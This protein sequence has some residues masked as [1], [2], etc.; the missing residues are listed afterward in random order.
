MKLKNSLFF[1]LFAAAAALLVSCNDFLDKEPS[2]STHKTI[3]TA[4]QLDAILGAYGRLQEDTNNMALAS[5][6]FAV[7]PELQHAKEGGYDPSGLQWM[8]WSETITDDGKTLWYDQGR[9]IY[10]ANLV[11]AN[12]DEVSGDAELKANLKAEAHLVRAYSVFQLAL[13]YTLYYDGSNGGEMGIPLKKTVDFEESVA[14]ASLAD[15]WAFIDAD[16]QEALK[17][18]APFVKNGKRM[19]WRGTTV[20][21]HAFAARYYLYRNDYDNAL[22]QVEA[23]LA[24]Y[25]TLKDF[26]T[27]MSYHGR[28]DTF[29]IKDKE[30]VDETVT[31]KYPY[32]H[33]MFYQTSGYP[34][35]FG[36]E[37]VLYA[38]TSAYNQYWYIPSQ[39][40]LDTYAADAPGGVVGNDL[41]YKYFMIQ[42]YSLKQSRVVPAFRYPGYCQFYYDSMI[43]GMTV[44]E[45][46]LI[47]AEVQARNGQWQDAMTTI[48]P[49]R[50]SRIA[51]GA[52]TKLDAI[53]QADAIKK[54][55]QERR[56]EMPFAMR[57]YDLKRLN[58]NDYAAD[59]VTVTRIFYPYT[60]TSVLDNDPLKTYTLAPN[61]RHYALQ[62]ETS[63]ISQSRG[64][65]QPNTY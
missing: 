29:V 32:T 50:K 38:R 65:I 17:T 15:T 47:K 61:S 53:S 49:I 57:W 59:D 48:D 22:T 23:V 25:K 1:V 20:S 26:N 3:K 30:G 54:I 10:S 60:K 46:L 11:L 42:D 8:L 12:V 14:R 41:R 39:G 43:S 19:V 55:L 33:Q 35:L 4:S 56:R 2:K 34:E 9:K 13:A 63:E 7:T 37:D 27:Q 45:M 18:T 62:I 31:I 21:A 44:P 40:L 36:Y 51:T 5:D 64:E 6:D 58:A 16:V 52:Y 24:E 28:V